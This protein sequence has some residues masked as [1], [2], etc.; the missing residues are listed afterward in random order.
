MQ[1]NNENIVIITFKHL[2]MNKILALNNPYDIEM[3]LN[4]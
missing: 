1:W 3:P 2:Q 4:K